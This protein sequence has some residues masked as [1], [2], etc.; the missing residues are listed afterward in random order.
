MGLRNI[1]LQQKED[2]VSAM[3][4]IIYYNYGHTPVS[5]KGGVQQQAYFNFHK[6]IKIDRVAV[7]VALIQKI[8]DIPQK[9]RT[10]N[11]GDILLNVLLS[12]IVF[13]AAGSIVGYFMNKKETR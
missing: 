8:M 4:L 13:A 1:R 7:K 6:V 10:G 9:I 3:L 12:I 11:A 5:L 2:P